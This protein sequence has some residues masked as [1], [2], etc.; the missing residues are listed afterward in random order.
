MAECDFGGYAT[1]NDMRCTD[2]RIIRS[3]AFKHQNKTRVPFVWQHQRKDIENYLG[4]ADLEERDDG[5]YARVK[6]NNSP[7][8]QIAKMLV[9]HGDLN[10][11]S[12]FATNLMQKGA[13]VLHG[14][15]KEVSLVMAGANPGAVID[16]VYMEHSDGSVSELD[17]E[18]VIYPYIDLDVMED[19]EMEHADGEKG[20][21]LQDILNELTDEQMD[22]VRALVG[23]AL[24][25]RDSD[26]DDEDME[27]DEE[28]D[29]S[30]K[31]A[32]RKTVKHSELDDE[33][34]LDL[35]D[36]EDDE[37]ELDLDDGL[38][39]DEDDEDEDFEHSD[40]EGEDSIM[41]VFENGDKNNTL[42]HDS[43]ELMSVLKDAQEIGS[44]QKSMLEHG[45]TGI[46]TLFPEA[47][48]VQSTPVIVSRDQGWVSKVMNSIKK[49]PFSRIKSIALNVT[50]DEARAQGY[51]KGKKKVEEQ[52]S[53]LKRVTLPQ[54]VYKMQALD[55]DD[56]LDITDFAVVDVMNTEMRMMLNEELARSALIGDGRSASAEGKIN[57]Q[58]IRPIY[59]DDE[60]YSIHYVV[61]MP[62]S[63]DI[64]ETSNAII[65]AAN[66]AR[67]DYKGSGTPVFFADPKTISTLLMARDKIGNRMYRNMTDLAAAMRVSEVVEVPVME[68]MTRTDDDGNTRA[69]H[70]IIVNLIDYTFGA[71][72]GGTATS[73]S[74]FDIQYNKER[75][76]IETRCSGA[77]TRPKS[78]IVLESIVPPASS[79]SGSGSN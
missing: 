5:I 50:M 53:A 13:D 1:K 76:L 6:L 78:A 11:L 25:E 41:N 31:K 36:I 45:I 71:D 77:L 68:N 33:D 47:R 15:I 79:G 10:S 65:D 40:D 3:G 59:T 22:A 46:E 14:D 23:M 51:V 4:H 69:L 30:K 17:T 66:F 63:G 2:G 27:E 73:F 62:T 74:D 24:S 48:P 54:T 64:T 20:R 57:P 58:N 26:S 16:N 44:L 34:E 60:V 29:V 43:E 8:A 35:D 32:S 21:T 18:V 19:Y 37:D 7:K 9:Q 72:K 67:S 39:D 28:I 12:I 61:D 52:F 38:E 49:S 70:G 75:Y 56:I 55:R 42:Q